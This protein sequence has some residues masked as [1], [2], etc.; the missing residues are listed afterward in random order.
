VLAVTKMTEIPIV[1]YFVMGEAVGIVLTFLVSL[2][3]SRK[4]MQK[5]S[6]DIESKILND[7]DDKLHNLLEIALAKPDVGK[8][9]N[10]DASGQSAEEAGAVYA[11]NIFAYAFQ[12]HKRGILKE[13]EW[14]GWLRRI[15]N[16]FKKGEISDYWNSELE[17]WFDPEF[18]DFINNEILQQIKQKI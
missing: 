14:N 2:Y 12:M 1:D 17:E 5:L 13:N 3:Y 16:S 9:F 15:R 4:Q 11:L 10:R 18:Q 7:L 8:I 6:T